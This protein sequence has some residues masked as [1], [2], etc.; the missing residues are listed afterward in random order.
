MAKSEKGKAVTSV[1]GNSGNLSIKPDG[2]FA[3]R[4]SSGGASASSSKKT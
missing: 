2:F 4:L 3:K 1:L